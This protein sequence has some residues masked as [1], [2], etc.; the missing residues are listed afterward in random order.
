MQ[1]PFQYGIDKKELKINWY[2]KFWFRDVTQDSLDLD[3]IDETR[4]NNRLNTSYIIQT[5][6]NTTS[7]AIYDTTQNLPVCYNVPSGIYIEFGFVRVSIS[8]TISYERI[9]SVQYK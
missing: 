7:Y 6:L 5:R 9:V 3:R 4:A 1:L 8:P 2:L